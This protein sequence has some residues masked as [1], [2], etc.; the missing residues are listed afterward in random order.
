MPRNCSNLRSELREVELVDDPKGIV[1]GH[2]RL[3]RL[4][5][6]RQGACVTCQRKS[7]LFPGRVSLKQCDRICLELPAA[8]SVSAENT[9]IG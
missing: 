1:G 5:C 7:E 8:F 4:C 9:P 6:H 3:M 2:E